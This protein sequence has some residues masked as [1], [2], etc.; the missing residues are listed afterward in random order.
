MADIGAIRV[1]MIGMYLVCSFFYIMYLLCD[2]AELWDRDE[3][4][5]SAMRIFS[6]GESLI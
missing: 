6:Y 5:K 1:A 2:A 3:G 4:G